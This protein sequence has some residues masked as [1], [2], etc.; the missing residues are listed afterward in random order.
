MAPATIFAILDRVLRRIYDAH[1]PHYPM[2]AGKVVL[3]GGDMR[4]IGPIPNEGQTMSQLHF[5]NSPA[6]VEATKFSLKI[7]MRTKDELEFAGWLKKIGE[8]RTKRYPKI[9]PGSVVFRTANIVQDYKLKT[10][11]DWTF[12]DNP[13]KSGKKSA[14]LTPFNRD[15]SKI[16]KAVVD[17]MPNKLH[18]LF[19]ED[20]IIDDT[21]S[22]SL[23]DKT[24]SKV[25]RETQELDKETSRRLVHQDELH[26][27]ME[28]GMPPHVLEV[29]VGT[30][31][32]LIKNL[33][34]RAGLVNGSRLRVNKITRD[35]LE[36]KIIS[37]FPQLTKA[38]RLVTLPRVRFLKECS[39][40]LVMQ[41]IQFPV[42]V[43]FAST[44]NKS[45][46][47]TLEK[48]CQNVFLLNN[49]YE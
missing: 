43:G 27:I 34:V 39:H 26:Q 20:S 41:R 17:S 40:A 21:P 12:G 32:S 8:G 22:N 48:V 23:M 30:I 1:E 13:T 11:I 47:L 24:P 33:D 28:T 38:T 44:I 25:P 46:G 37:D 14:I 36:C 49:H 4:Q 18:Q 31:V 19:S 10:L 5:R 15:C 6:F 35:R 7:N 42:R 29:K 45:Q 3:F 16:N 2:F 9:P